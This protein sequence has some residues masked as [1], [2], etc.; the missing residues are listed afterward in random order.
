[1]G[2]DQLEIIFDLYTESNSPYRAKATNE[3]YALAFHNFKKWIVEK[4]IH[5][6]VITPKTLLEW[7]DSM[8]ARNLK[9]STMALYVRHMNHLFHWAA[10]YGHWTDPH[11]VP[12]NMRIDR[13]PTVPNVITLDQHKAILNW[14]SD[15]EG[16]YREWHMACMLGWEF[17]MRLGDALT[18]KWERVDWNEKTLT[19]TPIKVARF[20]QA[21]VVPTPDYLLADLF[22]QSDDRDSPYITPILAAQYNQTGH[23]SVSQAYCY[24]FERACG[25][26]GTFRA[27]RHALVTRLM[28][29]DVNPGV[30]S[31]ITGHSL[32]MIM[33]YAHPSVASKRAAL[34]VA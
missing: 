33:R 20:K 19:Y 32:G 14:L 4:P 5:S 1:M 6:M 28:A 2:I 12:R 27:Y 30:I 18:Q 10:D 29:A 9:G 24:I 17:G 15:K 8:K 34:E 25:K 11:P 26:P 3:L 7:V 31:S 16:T 23:K 22:A 13:V 21:I